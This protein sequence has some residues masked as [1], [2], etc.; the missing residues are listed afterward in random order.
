MLEMPSVVMHAYLALIKSLFLDNDILKLETQSP[1]QVSEQL[2]WRMIKPNTG[3]IEFLLNIYTTM[4]VHI[5]S[6]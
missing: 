2:F 4:T 6:I 5:S 1:V 3:F